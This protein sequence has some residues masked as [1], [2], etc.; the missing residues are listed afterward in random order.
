MGHLWAEVGLG[1]G[2]GWF[3]GLRWGWFEWFPGQAMNNLHIFT[4]E[5][6]AQREEEW[7][8]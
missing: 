1:D 7:S 3:S 8:T 5:K 2:S 4:I 6:K